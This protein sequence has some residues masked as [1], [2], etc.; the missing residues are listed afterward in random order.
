MGIGW[1]LRQLT[2]TASCCSL[3]IVA[4]GCWH[5]PGLGGCVKHQP[6]CSRS[7]GA[8]SSGVTPLLLPCRSSDFCEEGLCRAV[9]DGGLAEGVVGWP[10]IQLLRRG[11]RRGGREGGRSLDLLRLPEGIP[12]LALVGGAGE[13]PCKFLGPHHISFEAP[14]SASP[15]TLTPVTLATAMEDGEF[16]WLPFL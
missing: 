10:R 14:L 16:M 8:P 13:K 4:C 3:Q 15:L 2:S 7:A 6:P 5:L 1:D 11:G 12:G 9:G